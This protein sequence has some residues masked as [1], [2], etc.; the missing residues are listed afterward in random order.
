MFRNR[1]ETK[2]PGPN[3]YCNVFGCL[4]S[5]E[6]AQKRTAV[7]MTGPCMVTSHSKSRW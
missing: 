6:V 3:G 7:P 4:A 5:R 1:P 2:N